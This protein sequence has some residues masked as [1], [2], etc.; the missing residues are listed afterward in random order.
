MIDKKMCKYVH[1]VVVLFLTEQ[2]TLIGSLFISDGQELM[3]VPSVAFR[4]HSE[5]MQLTAIAQSTDDWVLH[6]QGSRVAS[7]FRLNTS[8]FLRLVFPRESNSWYV[9]YFPSVDDGRR[10]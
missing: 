5:Q 10:Y 4:Y 6:T 8:L 9:G 2:A 7:M 1:L 3:L